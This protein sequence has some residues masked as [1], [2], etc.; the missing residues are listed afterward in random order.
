MTETPNGRFCWGELL[1]TDP[2]AAADFYSAVIGWGTREWEGSETPYSVW[3]NGEMPVGGF[4]R[5]PPE[6]AA[7]GAPP[8]WLEYISTPDAEACALKAENR[9][10]NL[11]NLF[12]IPDVGRMAI[13]ADPQ[14]AVI[15]AYQPSDATPGH[16][17]PASIGEFSWHEL[18]TTDAD[19]AWAF[20]S[21][22]FGWEAAERM[23]MGDMGFYQTFGRGA[24]PLGGIFNG[25]PEMPAVGWLLYVRVEDVNAAVESVK[26]AGG[27]IL[28]GPMEVPGGDAIAQCMDPP[29][30]AFA[31]PAMARDEDEEA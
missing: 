8:H 18:A 23:D 24:R 2:D 29:G 21:E 27:R 16:D 20:Y 9:G 26:A 10:G 22:V 13:I 3:M 5:L 12:D 14:G 15:T 28:N 17:G 30:G 31:V 1:T 4:M 11:L 19:A 7:T 6:V 25:P